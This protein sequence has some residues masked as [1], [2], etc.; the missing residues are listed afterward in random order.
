MEI[1]A[2]V[3]KHNPKLTKKV[4]NCRGSSFYENFYEKFLPARTLVVRE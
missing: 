3:H 4:K 1:Y 2:K